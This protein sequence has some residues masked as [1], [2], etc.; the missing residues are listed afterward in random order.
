MSTLTSGT[1]T[2]TG[3]APRT[4]PPASGPGTATNASR[5]SGRTTS[6]VSTPRPVLALLLGV[7]GLALALGTSDV[8]SRYLLTALCVLVLAVVPQIPARPVSERKP[9]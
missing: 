6:R 5:A 8:N 1:A 9:S 7:A 4:R 3:P 2:A